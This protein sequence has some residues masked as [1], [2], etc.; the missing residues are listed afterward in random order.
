MAS[1][2][3]R[4][5]QSL[6]LAGSARVGA[7]D[8]RRR[9]ASMLVPPR[10]LRR[11]IKQHAGITG[12][13]LRVPHRKT[14]ALSRQDLL[15]IVEPAE[16]DQVGQVVLTDTVILLARPAPQTIATQSA[17]ALR[18]KYWR[19]LFHVRV[20]L[21]LEQSMAE[22]RFG[23][24]SA[25]Q[26]IAELGE[27]EFAEIRS[28]LRQEDFLLPPRERHFDLRRIRGRLS[29]AALFRPAFAL[30]LFS[31]AAR[32]SVAWTR[33]WARTSTPRDCSRPR[34][35]PAPPTWLRA[36]RRI[37]L[38]VPPLPRHAERSVSASGPARRATA[39]GKGRAHG[40]GGQRG[41]GGDFAHSS[42][43][44]TRRRRG[45]GRTRGRSERSGPAR[46]AT[47]QGL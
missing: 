25:R 20:H 16:L 38:V 47:R 5:W 36:A 39:V 10:I 31:R 29:G 43:S 22:E 26:R 34:G 21:A 41:A 42:R 37:S 7:G 28:V 30:G 12:F 19:L 45:L 13:G 40:A 46:R 17:D 35:R 44:R 11:V 2:P 8:P 6:C 32:Y 27:A 14:Y 24:E 1:S 18:A 3:S 23:P 33:S 9:P 4:R 15:A